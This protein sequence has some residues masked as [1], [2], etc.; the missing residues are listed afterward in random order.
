MNEEMGG[1]WKGGGD[2]RHQRQ[3]LYDIDD[4]TILLWLSGVSL[5][6]CYLVSSLATTTTFATFLFPRRRHHCF[7]STATFLLA[8]LL[9]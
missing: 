7:R 9:R 6:F 3:H 5:L 2:A 4:D 8:F 1:K